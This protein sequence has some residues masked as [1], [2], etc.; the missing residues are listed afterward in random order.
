MV[1][2]EPFRP[3]R[4]G[5]SLLDYHP[6]NSALETGRPVFS[7]TL[8]IGPSGKEA[9]LAV[10]PIKNRL[11]VV[12][13]LAGGE[14]DPTSSA[15]QGMV[16]AV[17][18]GETGYIEVVDRE[19]IVL[20]SI[21]PHRLLKRGDQGE[22]LTHLIRER[23]PQVRRYSSIREGNRGEEREVL[24]FAPLLGLSWGVNIR[25]SERE[26]L[27]P[28]RH[29]SR[30]FLTFGLFFLIISLLLAYGTARSVV[31]PVRIL[32]SASQRIAEG[33][34]SDPIPFLGEDE[35]GR[36]GQSFDAMR[37]KLQESLETIEEWNRELER[38]IQ[39]RTRELEESQEE[40]RRKEEMRGE[41]LRRVITVQEEERK[42]ISREL[43]DDTSQA[44]A[45]LVLGLER[46]VSLRPDEAVEKVKELKSLTEGVLEGVHKLVYDLRPSVLDD[47][48][49]KSAIRWYADTRLG[50]Q[51]VHLH[52]ETSGEERRLFPQVETAVFRVAQ[53]A[54][55]NIAKHA[56]AE[57]VTV[58]LEFKESSLFLEIEDDGKGFD[59]EKVTRLADKGMGLGLLGMEERISLLQGTLSI[60]SEP[61]FGTRITLEVPLAPRESLV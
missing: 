53:E 38:R 12:V 16:P 23:R 6:I 34:L 56:E 35:I 17:R 13:G 19:G 9:V 22:L 59:M 11:G 14:I 4:L 52:F 55:T 26:A 60:E 18:L 61:G 43:H 36:L 37:L 48:G 42:R 15:F 30:R 57:N 50:S 46:A 45:A 31:K 51:G 21:R 32:T 25:Q 8:S 58:H 29:L 49:L 47:L 33:Q 44:L 54:I 28:A 20:A 5:Q 1:W 2:M 39:E 7:D 27:A 40:L 24:A 41:L 3:E 10:V